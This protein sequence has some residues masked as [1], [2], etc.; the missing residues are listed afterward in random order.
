MN[1]PF[2]LFAC[3]ALLLTAA[4]ASAQTVINVTFSGA[5]YTGVSAVPGSTAGDVWNSWGPPNGTVD[6]SWL[7]DPFVDA[8]GAA[9]DVAGQAFSTTYELWAGG[10]NGNA[11]PL[12]DSYWHINGAGTLAVTLTGLDS[13]T[14]YDLYVYGARRTD[15]PGIFIGPESGSFTVGD[16]TLATSYDGT[17]SSYDENVSYVHFVSLT[18]DD[19]GMIEFSTESITNGFSLAYTS[20]P[21]PEPAT[22]AA[23][24]GLGVYT[25]AVVRRRRK[26]A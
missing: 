11:I 12:F 9:T 26:A 14:T 25:L 20:T 8:T 5:P 6:G 4:A 10:I 15:D 7:S 2:R 24:A 1:S 22:Y 19:K 16:T 23:L 3:V 17:I 21:V 18:P 13:N